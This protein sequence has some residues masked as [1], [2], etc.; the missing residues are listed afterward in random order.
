MFI[1]IKLLLSCS[2]LNLP[3]YG[4]ARYPGGESRYS[5]ILPTHHHSDL[6]GD[7]SVVS[8]LS[9]WFYGIEGLGINSFLEFRVGC[10]RDCS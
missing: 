10:L 3:T 6:T 1:F 7:D 5:F 8:L 9:R 4:S 2:G